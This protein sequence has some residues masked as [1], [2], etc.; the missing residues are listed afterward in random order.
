M[1]LVGILGAQTILILALDL[2]CDTRLCLWLLYFLPLLGTARHPSVRLTVYG[3]GLFILLVTMVGF[4]KLGQTSWEEIFVPRALVIYALGLTAVLLV[5]GKHFGTRARE[6]VVEAEVQMRD[7]NAENRLRNDL[8]IARHSLHGLTQQHREA[9][10]AKKDAEAGRIA[11][12]VEK[13][14]GVLE[15]RLS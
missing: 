7:A 3:A 9:C 14:L 8:E 6:A 4:F 1:K 10:L 5:R 15:E 12:E 13:L 2:F 11:A